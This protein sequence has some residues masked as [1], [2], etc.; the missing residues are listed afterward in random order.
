MDCKVILSARAIQDLSEI[1]RYF[2]FDN[3]RAAEEF[4]YG[5]ID[6]AL[7]FRANRPSTGALRA[8]AVLRIAF[9]W[10]ICQ[11]GGPFF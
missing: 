5:L 6:A 11:K 8:D 3:P 10:R 7:G 1:V 4:G 9:E 2:S